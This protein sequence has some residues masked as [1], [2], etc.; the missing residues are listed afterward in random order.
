V[1]Y[2]QTRGGPGI[3]SRTLSYN[4]YQ[5]GLVEFNI[6]YSSAMAVL[7]IIMVLVLIN[8]FIVGFLRGK[9]I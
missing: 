4:L 8:L 6:G 9:E 5:A 1:I 7:M 3:A 2:A